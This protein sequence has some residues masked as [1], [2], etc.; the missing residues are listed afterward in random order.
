MRNWKRILCVAMAAALA[1]PPVGAYAGEQTSAP[2]YAQ[3][4]VIET[5]QTEEAAT[6]AAEE[7]KATEEAE[8]TEEIEAVTEIV[9]ETEAVEDEIRSATVTD[10]LLDEQTVS[11]NGTYT[12]VEYQYTEKRGNLW[13]ESGCRGLLHKS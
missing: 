13:G 10:T 8:V 11:P 12:G 6:E 3:E 7:T 2:E 9:E 5:E 4:S 1:C